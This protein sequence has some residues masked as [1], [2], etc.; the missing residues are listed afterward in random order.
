MAPLLVRER[1]RSTLER[2]DGG[3]KRRECRRS[4]RSLYMCS[5]TP[6]DPHGEVRVDR[7]SI[8]DVC[9]HSK[10]R[11]NRNSLGHAVPGE[12]NGHGN[13]RE[14]SVSASQWTAKIAH[15]CRGSLILPKE[16]L[17]RIQPIAGAEHAARHPWHMSSPNSLTLQA[18]RS[19]WAQ[20]A[21][22]M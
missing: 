22:V 15:S 11:S 19:S 6:S 12:V 13:L 14:I 9:E 8:G 17:P 16:H 2:R 4:S 10:S 1:T 5:T 20:E 18:A 7:P 21:R 3:K